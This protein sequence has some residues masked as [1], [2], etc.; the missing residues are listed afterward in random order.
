[1][2]TFKHQENMEN[3]IHRENMA[4]FKRRLAQTKDVTV[5]GM[6]LRLLAAEQARDVPKPEK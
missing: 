3:F 4:I 6:L 5:R 1:M 2:E